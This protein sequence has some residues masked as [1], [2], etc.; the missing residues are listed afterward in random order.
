MQ[1]NQNIPCISV[2]AYIL[3]QFRQKKGCFFTGEALARQ[4]GVSRVAVWKGVKAL[5]AAGYPIEGD[6]KGYRWIQEKESLTGDD[7]LYPW[8]FEEREKLFHHW[9]STDSTMNRAAE[10]AGRL[11]PGGSVITAEEQT[12]GRGRNSRTWNSQKGGLFFTLLERPFLSALE[13]PKLSMAAQ[14]ASA[15]AISRMSGKR[16]L[17]RWPNDI[18]V[19]G[20]KIAGILTEFRAEGD[21][22][23]WIAIGMGIN[24]NNK[25]SQKSAANRSSNYSANSSTNLSELTGHSISRRETLLAVL[26]EWDKIKNADSY[27]LGKHWNSMAEGRG[28]KVMAVEG[29]EKE[30]RPVE[31]GIFLGVDVLGRGVIKN[32]RDEKRAFSPGSV[33]FLF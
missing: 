4:L 33:S 16:A 19:E 20:K 10:L 13:Y 32:D 25:V 18:Y 3:E 14:I 31:R 11:Y 7:F 22:L 28:R 5:I 27:E 17:L 24:V 23:D 29:K 1:V 2:K 8:E 15:R 26:N 6:D 9:V 21:R 12:S 30:N